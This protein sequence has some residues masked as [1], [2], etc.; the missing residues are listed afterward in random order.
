MELS[1]FSD[2]PGLSA[3]YD[4]R[5]GRG[6]IAGRTRWAAASA[7]KITHVTLKGG[8]ARETVLADLPSVVGNVEGVAAVPGPGG[9]YRLYIVTDNNFEDNNPTRLLAFDWKP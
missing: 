2:R 7:S 4:G 6:S 8:V 1:V 3:G 9:G 5:D